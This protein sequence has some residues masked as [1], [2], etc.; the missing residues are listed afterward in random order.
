MAASL[1]KEGKRMNLQFFPDLVLYKIFSY[2]DF[3]DLASVYIA[4]DKR[5]KYFSVRPSILKTATLQNL[6]SMYA[7]GREWKCEQLRSLCLDLPVLKQATLN[8][9]CPKSGINFAF[10]VSLLH[11]APEEQKHF[12]YEGDIF[13]AEDLPSGFTKIRK[14]Y[15]VIYIIA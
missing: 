15:L 9:G 1:T 13:E 10:L 6:A 14:E 5:L 4:G 2:L 8:I 3:E 7:M 11:D 12:Y